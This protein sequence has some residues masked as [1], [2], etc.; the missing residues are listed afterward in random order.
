MKVSIYLGVSVVPEEQS[1][2]KKHLF[3]WEDTSE[4]PVIM[5]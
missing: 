4:L 5:L 1:D 3:A 2:C